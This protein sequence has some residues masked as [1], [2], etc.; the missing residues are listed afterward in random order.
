M[1]KE[2]F[3]EL[4]ESVKQ[5]ATIMKG[6][7]KPSRSIGFHKSEVRKIREQYGLSLTDSLLLFKKV[8]PL[9]ATGNKVGENL[10]D[11][12]VFYCWLLSNPLKL[13][14]IIQNTQK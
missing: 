12:L 13:Y 11:Q 6:K 3:V 9:S 14:W 10:N 8:S 7:A 1:K 4:L 5:C 2:L